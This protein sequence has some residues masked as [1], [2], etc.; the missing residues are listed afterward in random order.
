MF[1]LTYVNR[2]LGSILPITLVFQE[3]VFVIIDI[4]LLFQSL[5]HEPKLCKTKLNL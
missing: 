2:A 4:H 1:V 3:N 5:A